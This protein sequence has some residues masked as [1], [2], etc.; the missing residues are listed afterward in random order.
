MKKLPTTV[1]E[2]KLGREKAS[3]QAWK[4]DNLIE[5][6]PRQSS[7]EYFLTLVHE[8]AHLMFPEWSEKEVAK[9]ER[10]FGNFLWRHN[11]R[12]IK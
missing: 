5:I 1:K 3:G 10:E 4:E 12:I 7:K 11:C 9:F 2:K 8:K 6:D